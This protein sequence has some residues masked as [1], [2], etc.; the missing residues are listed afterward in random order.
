M[1][2]TPKAVSYALSFFAKD[3]DLEGK[4]V[5]GY[6]ARRFRI[7]VCIHDPSCM[8][9]AHLLARIR[10]I[11]GAADYR[12]DSEVVAPIWCIERS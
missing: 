8:T 11:S 5:P 1:K 10:T 12:R 6:L 2:H 7:A 9:S 3:G 4:K